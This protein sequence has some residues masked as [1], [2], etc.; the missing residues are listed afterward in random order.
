MI[1]I[2]LG[3]ILLGFT[4]A[5][6]PNHWFPL[7]AVSISQKWNDRESFHIT[8]ITGF[9]HTLSTIAFG[10]VLGFIGFELSNSIEIISH[11]VAPSLLAFI[12]LLFI[13]FHYAKGDSDAHSH[14]DTQKIDEASHRSKT[15]VVFTLAVMMMFSPCLEIDAYYFAA[16]QFGWEGI[17]TLSVIYLV[18]TLVMLSILVHLARKGMQKLSE[19]LHFLEHNE[20]L[21]NGIILIALAIIMFFA[22]E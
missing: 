12:G 8:L 14:I 16:G 20:K 3:S 5:L 18:L 9:F 1:Q 15:A 17:L 13:I 4:H 2:I 22:G 10:V 6:I 11:I 19:R 7:A 21:I